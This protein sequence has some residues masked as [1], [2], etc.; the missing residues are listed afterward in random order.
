MRMLLMTN[1]EFSSSRAVTLHLVTASSWNMKQQVHR[2]FWPAE[3]LLS[4]LLL[5][6][7]MH[8]IYAVLI[9]EKYYS[10]SKCL[11]LTL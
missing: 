8:E 1:V 6:W 9:G 5:L 11:T 3:H 10:D 4:E 7:I 2:N